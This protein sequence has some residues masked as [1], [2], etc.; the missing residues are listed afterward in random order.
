MKT[1]L[2]VMVAAGLAGAAAAQT[3]TLQEALS[4]K[5]M[6]L[7][8]KL[9]SLDD[10]W[11]RVSPSSGSDTA[12]PLALIYGA[13]AGSMGSSVSYTKGQTITIGNESYLVAYAAQNKALDAAKLN[14][15]MRSGQPPE[16]EKPTA[17][18]M[19][20]LSLLNLRTAGSFTDIRPFNL[21]FE[22]TGNEAAAATEDEKRVQEHSDASAKNLRKLGVAVNTYIS[23][24]KALPLLTNI[25]SA[26]QELIL[27]AGSK[28]VFLQP[29][30]KKPYRPNPALAG[31][32][33]AEFEKTD[34]VVLF[35]EETPAAD[36]TRNVLFLDGHVD[37]LIEQQWQRLKEAA[38]LPK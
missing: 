16:P 30:S 1:I 31:R 36:G 38:Q 23:E 37:R 26:E 21:D 28:D 29:Q 7:T 6:P 8:I 11:R 2:G 22:L 19:L 9:S 12:N 18:T 17:Q 13:R 35:Y 34:K 5:T 27:Y 33:P 3:M 10:T 24:R 25:R 14:A 32:K 15:L 20:S 4:G